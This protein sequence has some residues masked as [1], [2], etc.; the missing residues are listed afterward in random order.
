[1]SE[2][3]KDYSAANRIRE[4]RVRKGL[5]QQQLAEKLNLT[6]SSL[7]HYENGRRVVDYILAKRIAEVLETD[8]EYL[9]GLTDEEQK[10]Q[11]DFIRVLVDRMNRLSERNRHEVL[12]YAECLAR[13]QNK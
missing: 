5:T 4:L 6:A 2:G 3:N 12:G 11:D 7:G 1:M 13:H 8:D 9:M 10:P